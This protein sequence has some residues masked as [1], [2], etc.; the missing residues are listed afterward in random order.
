MDI[1]YIVILVIA[2]IAVLIFFHFVPIGLWIN[3]KTAGVRI[4]LASLFFMRLRRV[5][6]RTIVDA[7]IVA[8]KAGLKNSIT[9]DMLEA[10]YLARGN[11]E[12]VVK[13][14]IS[15]SKMGIDLPFIK[16]TAL[17]LKGEDVWA[18]TQASAKML[19]E[20]Q[21]LNVN[22]LK[23]LYLAGG[24]VKNVVFALAEASEKGMILSFQMAS[25]IDLAGHNVEEAVKKSINPLTGKPFAKVEITNK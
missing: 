22:S 25:D 7:L 5:E 17:D 21:T 3:A 4:S 16:A 13:A 20:Q 14:V 12:N 19:I 11:V 23:A 15:A 18:A 9:K 10:H 2:L 24:N 1:Y 6:P 8:H